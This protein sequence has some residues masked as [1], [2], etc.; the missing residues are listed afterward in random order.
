[1]AN[2]RILVFLLSA[3]SLVVLLTIQSC[4]PPV[5]VP[6][7]SPTP[8][9]IHSPGKFVW[10]DLLTD[11][12]ERAKRF[13]GP[14]LGWE[15]EP[16]PGDDEGRYTI[17]KHD[18]RT[19]GGIV[20]VERLQSEVGISQWLAYMSVSNVDWATDFVTSQGGAVLREPWDLEGRGRLSVVTDPQ[21][22]LLALIRSAGGDP[23]DRRANNHEWLWD[24]Y[25][26]NNMQSATSF[27][28]TLVGYSTDEVEGYEGRTYTV[29]KQGD[30][31]RAGMLKNPFENV[32]PNWLPYV[33]V[34]DPMPLVEKAKELGGEV[35][36]APDPK[37]RKGSVALVLDPNG[38]AIALQ[39]WPIE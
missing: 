12:V 24:E 15:F 32:K 1:M 2:R 28:G 5:P 22:A 31:P 36:V 8:T 20:Y 38:A 37:I 19:I 11:N 10:H 17:I 18:G 21:G 30:V 13:Y 25:F 29:F 14:L 34:E 26:S 35:V 16:L 6:A 7:V 4:A 9:E 33:R 27:Y 3:L 39:K 23:E